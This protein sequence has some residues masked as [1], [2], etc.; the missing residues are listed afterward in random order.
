MFVVFI[1]VDFR[2]WNGLLRI[3]FSRKRKT[4]RS[5]FKKPSVLSFLE[6]NHKICSALTNT[7]PVGGSSFKELCLGVL[8]AAKLEEKRS[9]SI[10][11]S[12]FFNLLLEFHKKKIYFQSAAELQTNTINDDLQA[13]PFSGKLYL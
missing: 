4:L 10:S 9:V 8:E 12:E 1:Q 2:E 5:I 11:T 7:T 13:N 3:C 6:Q